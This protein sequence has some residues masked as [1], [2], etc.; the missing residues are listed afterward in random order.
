MIKTAQEIEAMRESGHLLASML[1]Q[2][3]LYAKPGISLREIEKLAYELIAKHGVKSAFKGYLNYPS[4]IC[5]SLNEEVVHGIPND[6]VLDEGDLLSMDFGLIH[7]GM[8]SDSAITFGIGTIDSKKQQLIDICKQALEKGIAKATPGNT[9]N[10]IGAE[11]QQWVESHNMGIVRELVGHGIGH[12]LHE[13]PQ[14]PNF[15]TATNGPILKPGMTIA[16]EPMITLGGHEVITK[17]DDWTIATKDNSLS[18]HF[19]HTIAITADQPEI[20]TLFKGK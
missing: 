11:I 1:H 19:E 13:E 10:D 15:R 9:I 5:L 4:V 12:Q 17:E 18:A 16:I 6:R 2:L 20:L 8:Y 3:R 7:K 14:V